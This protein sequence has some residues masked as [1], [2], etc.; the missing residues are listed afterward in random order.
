MWSGQVGLA[1]ITHQTNNYKKQGSAELI[2][3]P[4][5]T[6][7]KWRRA[8]ML[9]GVAPS[10]AAAPRTVDTCAPSRTLARMMATRDCTRPR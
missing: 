6:K 9:R 10:M 2:H 4:N 1:D 8:G 3:P 7:H 5:K